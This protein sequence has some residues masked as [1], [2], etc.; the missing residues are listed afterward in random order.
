M[1]TNSTAIRGFDPAEAVEFALA[2]LMTEG[3]VESRTR[4]H[5][6][7]WSPDI[8]HCRSSQPKRRRT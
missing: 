1:P 6:P 7:P 3:E 5:P 4:R 8:D 2:G